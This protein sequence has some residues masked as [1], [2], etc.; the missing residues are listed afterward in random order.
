VLVLGMQDGSVVVADGRANCIMGI[1]RKIAN[2]GIVDIV[3]RYNTVAIV[4]STN[5]ISI[6][7]L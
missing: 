1:F 3:M 4:T 2:S 5:I 6:S 7:R